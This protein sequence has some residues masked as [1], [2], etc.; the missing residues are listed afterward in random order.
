MSRPGSDYALGL[1]ERHLE[2]GRVQ[3]VKDRLE[4]VERATRV[5][6]VSAVD[7][8]CE[9]RTGI[10]EGRHNAVRDFEARD[11]H[12][13][14]IRV[15]FD[16]HLGSVVVHRDILSAVTA[17]KPAPH[18]MK[19]FEFEGSVLPDTSKGGEQGM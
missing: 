11:G 3:G 18:F 14:V 17:P 15:G 1:D 13:D 5:G 12:F 2:L 8:D 10:G 7:R 16:Q 6:Q 4:R 19:E 9:T